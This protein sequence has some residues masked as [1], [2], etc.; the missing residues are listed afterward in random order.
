MATEPY[1]TCQ[2]KLG[3]IP[4]EA[5]HCVEPEEPSSILEPS[6]KLDCLP[7][8]LQARADDFA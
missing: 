3:S 6:G 7:C 2:M 5:F 1:F 4:G 8:V